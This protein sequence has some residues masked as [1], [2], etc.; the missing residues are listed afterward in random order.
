MALA[1]HSNHPFVARPLGLTVP[2][3]VKEVVATLVAADVVTDGAGGGAVR[4][5]T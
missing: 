2:L 4:S 1:P 3:A 5:N